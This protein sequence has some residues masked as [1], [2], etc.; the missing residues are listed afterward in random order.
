[1]GGARVGGGGGTGAG[2]AAN[3]PGCFAGA[4]G[5]LQRWAPLMAELHGKGLEPR[6]PADVEETEM[7]TDATCTSTGLRPYIK[8]FPPDNDAGC[9]RIGSPLRWLQGHM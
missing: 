2:R 4:G 8:D 3:R 5:A 9:A 1:M 6:L 7:H